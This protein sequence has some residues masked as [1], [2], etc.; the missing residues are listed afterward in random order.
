MNYRHHYHAGNYADVFKHVVL[1]LLI[2]GMQRK[3]K[4]FFY[5]DTHAGR[6][7]YDLSVAPVLPDGRERVPEW[8]AGIGRLYAEP[9]VST[10]VGDFLELLG[11][12][13][14]RKAGVRGSS[15]PQFYPGS[16]WI[17]RLLA[18]PQDRLALCELREDDAEALAHEFHGLDRVSV[19]A[20]DG[21]TA[22]KAMLPPPERRALV[23]IDPPFES[24]VEF[25]DVLNGLREAL[26]RF[27]S[28]T[29][30][31]WYP[32]TERARADD[33]LRSA[34]E[35]Q[36]PALVAE[37]NVAA[38]SATVRMKGCG[39]LVLNPPWRIDEE[40]APV[41]PELAQRLR[42]DTAAGARAWWLVP[43]R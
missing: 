1:M 28:G 8:P 4:G 20:M 19:H 2:R 27:P 39:L 21:Y 16:P 14:E 6:G 7:G 29:Y 24:K 43:E 9:P 42:A 22:L 17:A 11:R 37:L 5:L 13:E 15:G 41:L 26:R 23:L 33:F 34:A 36:V 38:E 32:V 40:I 12:Y 35:W 30:V 31:V 25:A 3:E 10:A 18:R